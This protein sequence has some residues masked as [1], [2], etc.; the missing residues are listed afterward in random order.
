[1]MEPV[2]PVGQPARVVQ[3]VPQKVCPSRKPDRP[4]RAASFSMK[5]ILV[6][7]KQVKVSLVLLKNLR[8]VREVLVL[9]IGDL[10]LRI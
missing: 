8:A 9:H 7:T 6:R 4:S 10:R 3:L 2:E 5:A 1:M